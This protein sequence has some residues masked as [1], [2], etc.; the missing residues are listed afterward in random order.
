MRVARLLSIVF[1]ID[2]TPGIT[3]EALAAALGV[4]VRTIYRDVAAL[5]VAGVPVY[6]VAGHGGGLHLVE[7]Y[8]SRAA[9]LGA[10]E[11][12]ALLVGVIPGVAEQLGLGDAAGRAARKVQRQSGAAPEQAGPHGGVLVDPVGWYRSASDV[13][14][15]G[16]VATGMRAR[17]VVAITYRRWA[18]PQQVRRRIAPLGLV[19]K[20]GTWYV[21]ARRRGEVRT[22]RIDQIV[23]ATVTAVAF[24]PDPGF[25]LEAAWAAFVMSF[26]ERQRVV[27]ADVVLSRRGRDWLRAEG[28][29]ALREAI[30][31]AL[32]GHADDRDDALAVTLPYESVARATAELLRLGGEVDV[33]GPPELRAAIRSSVEDLASNYLA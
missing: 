29:A 19:L 32:G 26:H 3:A 28:D 21:M 30:D 10:D 4:S 25:D 20:A 15:L 23:R 33:V 27:G 8:R 31:T 7:G 5:Q 1:E 16:A 13:P 17:R 11:A 12:A 6:G 14:H 2:S 22:Y 18:E 24:D 9:S